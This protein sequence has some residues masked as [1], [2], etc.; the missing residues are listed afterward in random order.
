MKSASERDI[1]DILRTIVAGT[2]AV[3]GED[4]FRDLVRHLAE[5]LDV[6]W[7]FVSE[8]AAGRSRVRTLAFWSAEGLLDN[9]EYDLPGTPCEAVLA[10]ETRL[11][12]EKVAQLFPLEKELAEMGAESYL[13]MPLVDSG[14]QVMGHLAIID[15]K[16]FYGEPQEMSVFGV[17]GARVTAELERRNATSALR[18]SEA[19]L[20]AILKCATDAIVTV[21]GRR[22]VTMFNESA[23][24]AFG[25]AA[26]WALGQPFDRFLSKP[27]RHLL[28]TC[29]GEQPAGDGDGGRKLWAPEGISALRAD[30]SEFPVELTISHTDA[31][32]EPLFTLI[33]RDLNERKRAERKLKQL[34]LETEYLK[35]EIRRYHGATE[36]VSVSRVM[37]D[38]LAQVD[39]V[40]VTD[41]TVLLMGETGVGKELIARAVHERSRRRERALVKLN[42][43]A[44][45]SE[46]VESELFGHEKGAFS[47]AIARRVGRFELANHGTLFLDEVGELSLSAQ[48]KLLRV[49]QEQEFERVGGTEP[50][51]TDA[52]VVAAT[53]RDLADMVEAGGFRQDLLFRLNVFPIRIPPLRERPEDI[54]VLARAFLENLVPKLDKPL[55]EIDANSLANLRRYSWPGNV[56]ELQNVIERAAILAETPIVEVPEALIGLGCT[57]PRRKP[58]RALKDAERE[59]IANVLEETGWTVEGPG[60]AAE[61][62]GLAPSTLRSKMNRLGIRRAD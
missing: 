23:E 45:P 14:G 11:Y 49:L 27:F 44:L 61:V 10:G 36:I 18:R 59:H 1:D 52:R 57:A 35:E 51:R 17:F 24:K 33:L 62:L 8:F 48:A 22:R 56:R 41:T 20:A 43:A 4:F 9:I 32:G 60:G 12:P 16:P 46:L 31:D 25:C 7:A 55:R 34:M 5:A 19:R 13:A 58:T 15:D 21:D 38:L 42:C 39:R 47:G 50:L 40:A 54:P 29:I 3:I 6:R 26:S 28:E 53:N 37:A 2:A 30:G